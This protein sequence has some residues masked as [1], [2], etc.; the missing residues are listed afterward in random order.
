MLENLQQLNCKVWL[1]TGDV[2]ELAL[3]CAVD[4][5]LIDQNEDQRLTL[6]AKNEAQLTIEVRNI[7]AEIKE[8]LDKNKGES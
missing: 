7:L 5:Q 8:I 3:N 4:I 6:N 2:K 1:L